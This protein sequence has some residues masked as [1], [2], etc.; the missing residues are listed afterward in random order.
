MLYNIEDYVMATF[1]MYAYEDSDTVSKEIFGK[2]LTFGGKTWTFNKNN[3]FYNKLKDTACYVFITNDNTDVAI[4][5]RGTNSIENWLMDFNNISYTAWPS[6]VTGSKIGT[7]WLK[8]WQ[9]LSEDVMDFLDTLLLPANPHIIVTGHS[10]GASMATIAAVD[11]QQKIIS[12]YP[13]GKV[14][15]LNFSSPFV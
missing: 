10:L 6:T 1:C 2:G 11:I 4:V 12:K 13:G 14:I 5:F 8:A 9:S 7:G 15:L 3:F